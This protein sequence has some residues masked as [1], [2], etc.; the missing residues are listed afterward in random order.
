MIVIFCILFST[1]S[2]KKTK[3]VYPAADRN[4][5]P[6]LQ[7]LKLYI[8]KNHPS[9]LLE[10]S[11]GSGQHISHFAPNFPNV[12]FQPTELEKGLF[13]SIDA[14][15]E[16]SNV[17][18]IKEAQFLDV[19]DSASGWLNQTLKAGSVD[20]ILNCNMMHISEYACTEGIL[21]TIYLIS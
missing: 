12:T 8:N 21:L 10:I 19:K 3:Q 5:D 7:T 6:I 13:Q 17:K 2:R 18:N 4:K 14:Y 1:S 11:S 16:D 9:F 20:Y 15:A